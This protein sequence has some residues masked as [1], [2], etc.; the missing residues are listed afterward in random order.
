[1]ACCAL[2][3]RLSWKKHLSCEQKRF[4]AVFNGIG[5]QRMKTFFSSH[6][7]DWSLDLLSALVSRREIR[8]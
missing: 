5:Q 8:E 1:M 6:R 4:P 3:N 7:A 2:V